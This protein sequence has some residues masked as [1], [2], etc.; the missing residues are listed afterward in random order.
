[1][2]KLTLRP[3]KKQLQLESQ[4]L[5]ISDEAADKEM[6]LYTFTENDGKQPFALSNRCKSRKGT[7]APQFTWTSAVMHSIQNKFIDRLYGTTKDK[8]KALDEIDGISI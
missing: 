2:S 8:A 4:L 6:E 1:M 5:L 7:D 3:S